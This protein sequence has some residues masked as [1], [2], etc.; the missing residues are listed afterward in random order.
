MAEPQKQQGGPD[1]K[2]S[3][4]DRTAAEKQDQFASAK[5]RSSPHIIPSIAASP[6]VARSSSKKN[7]DG[8]LPLY[9]TVTTTD[10]R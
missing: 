10:K 2:H 6:P 4:H 5:Q 9:N 8:A 7:I 1:R 3:W